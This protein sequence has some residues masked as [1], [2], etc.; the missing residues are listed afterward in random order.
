MIKWTK[1]NEHGSTVYSTSINTGYAHVVYKIIHLSNNEFT[2]WIRW[3]NSNSNFQI[4]IYKS[5]ATAKKYAVP[6]YGISPR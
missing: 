4:G 6:Q 3:M 1:T 5:L 2:L